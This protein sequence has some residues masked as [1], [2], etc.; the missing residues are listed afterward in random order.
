VPFINADITL[1]LHRPPEGEW[2]C[3][4]TTGRSSHEGIATGDGLMH[5][6]SGLVGRCVAASLAQRSRPGG[7]TGTR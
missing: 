6:R 4:E 7:G 5:D 3:L 2:L 1:Y